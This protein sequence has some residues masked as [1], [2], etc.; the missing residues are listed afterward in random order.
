VAHYLDIL[1]LPGA[2]PDPAQPALLAFSCALGTFI[3]GAVAR[4]RRQPPEA[5]VRATATGTWLGAGIG[6]AIY[7]TFNLEGSI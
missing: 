7:F 2:L 3:G 1:L 5:V 6:L 4:A